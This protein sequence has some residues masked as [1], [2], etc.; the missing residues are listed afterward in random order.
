ME[1]SIMPITEKNRTVA[2]KLEIFSAQKGYIESVKECLREAD[3]CGRWRTVGIYE[4]E[5]MIGFAMYGLFRCYLPFG[6][7]W[8]DRLLIDRR[9]QGKGYGKAA[10]NALLLRL[11]I[12][13]PHRKKVFLSVYDGNDAALNL[14]RKFGFE[15]NGEKDIHGE[16]V[17]IG[18]LKSFLR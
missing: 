11:K 16:N 7:L 9:F 14:Y 12:E 10:V 2:E 1:L 15:M 17:M 13:Y 3:M 5:T 8:L 4:G 18:R 6:R